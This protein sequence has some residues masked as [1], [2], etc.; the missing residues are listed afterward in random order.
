MAACPGPCRGREQAQQQRAVRLGC[1]ERGWCR[2]QA[3]HG[4][5]NGRR[6][7]QLAQLR[8]TSAGRTGRC[9]ACGPR[10]AG[11]LRVGPGAGG[12][13]RAAS[14]Q[15]PLVQHT[16]LASAAPPAVPGQQAA[17]L[18]QAAAKHRA[19]QRPTRVLKALGVEDQQRRQVAQA[20]LLDRVRAAQAPGVAGGRAARGGVVGLE[21]G[22]PGGKGWRALV[23]GSGP[24]PPADQPRPAPGRPTGPLT[25]RR[26]SARPRPAARRG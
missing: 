6:A 10:R 14:E 9:P 19:E 4:W 25:A 2:E 20:Q 13:S 5:Q 22:T 12:R 18:K 11:R 1:E 24:R 21:A 7:P 8:R 15:A 3:Q 16:H 17:P 26:S 23:P